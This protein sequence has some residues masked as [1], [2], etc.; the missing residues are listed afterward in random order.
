MVG[1]R[2]VKHLRRGQIKIFMLETAENVMFQRFPD[3]SQGVG[4][5]RGVLPERQVFSSERKKGTLVR[6][7]QESYSDARLFL[8][9]CPAAHWP[10]GS[11]F[12]TAPQRLRLALVHP[13]VAPALSTGCDVPYGFVEQSQAC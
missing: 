2:K 7:L 5:I 10:C 4:E 3:K 1:A 11:P 12:P 8:P 9:L 13:Y 6:N